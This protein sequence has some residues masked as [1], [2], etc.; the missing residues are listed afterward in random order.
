MRGICEEICKGM[1]WVRGMEG[2]SVREIGKN[3]ALS[4]RY[5]RRNL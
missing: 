5:V 1:L 3:D 4:E 2:R